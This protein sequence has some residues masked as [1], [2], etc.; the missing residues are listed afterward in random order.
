MGNN[1]FVVATGVEALTHTRVFG[2]KT[3][4]H[5]A[6][7][8][9]EDDTCPSEDPPLQTRTRTLPDTVIE[10]VSFLADHPAGGGDPP[11]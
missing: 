2:A 9:Y 8:Q 6:C 1:A 4:A 11:P 3:L 7:S 10:I 5:G